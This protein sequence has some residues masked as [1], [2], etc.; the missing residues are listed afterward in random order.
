MLSGLVTGTRE[1]RRRVPLSAIPSRMQ[2]ALLA[3]EDRRFYSHPGID[4]ISLVG[5]VV[6]NVTSSRRYPV[7]RSTVTQQLSRMFFLSEEFNAELQSGT[8]GRTWGSYRRKALESFMAVILETKATKD[9]ILELYLN[10][11]YLGNRGSFAVHG[12]AEAARIFFSKDVSNLTLAEAALIAGIIQNPYQHSP[13]VNLDRAKERRDVVLAAMAEADFISREAATRPE[14]AGRTSSSRRRQRGAIFRRL[15]RRAA[16][17]RLS[18]HHPAHRPLDIYT[19]LDLNL[20]R[21]AQEAVRA[22]WRAWTT[23]VEAPAQ[24][25]PGASGAHRRRSAF[26]RGAGDGRWALLQPVAVQPRHAARR[27]PGSTFKPFV[28]LAAFEHARRTRAAPTSDA[29]HDGLGRADDVGL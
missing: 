19:T 16:A 20:Q 8:R 11:V 2:Q 6:T 10:D 1:K 13:F 7:G 23:L 9:E 12:V 24:A 5:A 15:P 25:G 21:Y 22:G 14:R 18:R 26:W 4:P 28:Y 27:Q 17:S 3:I 29:G